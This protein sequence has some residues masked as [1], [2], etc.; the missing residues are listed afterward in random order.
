MCV[1]MGLLKRAK[2]VVCIG[3]DVCLGGD[4]DGE[5][6]EVVLKEL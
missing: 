6:W 5:W 1:M 2:V 3:D 4:G